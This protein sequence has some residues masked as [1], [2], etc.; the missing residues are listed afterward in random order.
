MKLP[1]LLGLLIPAST[2]CQFQVSAL[3]PNCLTSGKSESE[4]LF[5]ALNS[6]SS[7]FL[8]PSLPRH[9][10]HALTL[11]TP[12]LP[13]LHSNTLV[14]VLLTL[15]R[16][17][18]ATPQLSCPLFCSVF[19]PS[20]LP[21]P[22]YLFIPFLHS[23]SWNSRPVGS[24]TIHDLRFSW[25]LELEGLFTLPLLTQSPLSPLICCHPSHEMS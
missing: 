14:H 17:V 25:L 24:V 20:Y 2:L 6:C 21:T 5:R 19:P 23:H 7:S 8:A 3:I 4:V 15:F 9:R 12:S 22:H 16:P 10:S 11:P 13:V 1:A 18:A